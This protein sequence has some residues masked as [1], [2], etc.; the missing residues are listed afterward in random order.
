[1]EWKM[2]ELYKIRNDEHQYQQLRLDAYQL[3]EQLNLAP[4]GDST[5]GLEDCLNLGVTPK[6]FPHPWHKVKAEFETSPLSSGSTEVPDISVWNGSALVLSEKALTNLKPTLYDLGEF[7]PLDI[8]GA[9]FYIFNLTTTG[10]INLDRSR[11]SYDEGSELA[12]DIEELVF[13]EKDIEGKVLFSAT[14]D[15]LGGVYCH[16]EFRNLCDEFSL[17]GLIFDQDIS[18]IY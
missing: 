12:S 4:E 6:S 16:Q 2:T 13:V 8:H 18:N 5:Q 1:M 10:E 17:K 7:L 11:F 9:T 3:C 14:H 15:Y